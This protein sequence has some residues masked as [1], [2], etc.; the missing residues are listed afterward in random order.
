MGFFFWQIHSNVYVAIATCES[1]ALTVE[2]NGMHF[3]ASAL[4]DKE[5]LGVKR[6]NVVD[7]IEFSQARIRPDRSFELRRQAAE[8]VMHNDR[9]QPQWAREVHDFEDLACCLKLYR[10]FRSHGISETP[11][12][13]K[14]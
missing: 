8:L 5:N 14:L 7:G 10:A 11:T 13:L 2:G 1:D 9:R 12:C 4:T 3:W 6:L